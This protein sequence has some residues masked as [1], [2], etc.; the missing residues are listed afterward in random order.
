MKTIKINL[1]FL[2]LLLTCFSSLSA[3][4]TVLDNLGENTGST[5]SLGLFAPVPFIPA[6]ELMRAQEFVTGGTAYTNEL[7]TVKLNVQTQGG[8]STFQVA[9]HDESGG[10]PGSS[11]ATL[12]GANMPGTGE[13]SYMG[14]VTLAASTSYFIVVSAVGS[15]PIYEIN[16]TNSASITTDLGFSAPYESKVSTDGSWAAD[17]TN[18]RLLFSVQ[19]GAVLPV[20]FVAFKGEAKEKVNV[21]EWETASETNNDHF[22]VEHSLDGENFD[23]LGTENGRGA[24]NT[25]TN[26]RFDHE[27]PSAGVHYYRLKQVDF[28]ARFTYSEIISLRVQEEDQLTV[29]PNPARDQLTIVNGQGAAYIFNSLGQT[30]RE[31]NIGENQKTIRIDDLQEGHYFLQVLQVNGETLRKV[32]IKK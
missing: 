7:I 18:K 21:L 5:R 11:I 9:I 28:D 6:V 13:N 1:F 10:N 23:A 14:T 26:Y 29:Y 31:F 25:L 8:S 2:A 30:V 3:Q 12:S 16:S 4:V 20:D 15:D 27:N 24:D 17:G 22:V 19:I 32:F